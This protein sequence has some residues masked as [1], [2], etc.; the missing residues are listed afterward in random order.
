MQKRNEL[1]QSMCENT[2]DELTQN[3]DCPSSNILIKDIG[4]INSNKCQNKIKPQP[5]C[6][7]HVQHSELCPSWQQH[8][9]S[10]GMG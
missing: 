1:G 2:I 10:Y 3:M 5:C 9:S 7:S 4:L 8:L 6:Q